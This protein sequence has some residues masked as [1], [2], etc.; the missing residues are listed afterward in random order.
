MIETPPYYV[1]VYGGFLVVDEFGH[2]KRVRSYTTPDPREADSW[3]T[4]AETDQIAKWAVARMYPPELQYF[5]IFT[6]P[7]ER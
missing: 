5:A 4:F 1:A 2:A 6:I 7:G 3:Q